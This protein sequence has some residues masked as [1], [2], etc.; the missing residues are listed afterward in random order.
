MNIRLNKSEVRSS[1]C[2]VRSSKFGVGNTA[3]SETIAKPTL[4]CALASA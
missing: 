3:E 1:E 4:A 2:G